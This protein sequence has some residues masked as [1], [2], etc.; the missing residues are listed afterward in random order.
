MNIDLVLWILAFVLFL[1]AGFIGDRI[2][3]RFNLI[4]FGL[5]AAALTYIV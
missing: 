3:P 2:P 1:I 5:A 4:A